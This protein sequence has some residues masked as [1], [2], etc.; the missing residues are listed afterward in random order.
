MGWDESKG[1]TVVQ[2]TK[3][4]FVDY[5]FVVEPDIKPFAVADDLVEK[6]KS[7]VGE[8]PE[9]KR[10]RLKKDYAL[11]DFDVET[12]TSSR[13][14]A[15]WFEEAAAGTKN[16]KR[17]ANIIL[18]ELLAKLNE[19]KKSIADVE[20]SPRHISDLVNAI[21]SRRISSAQGKTVFAKMMQT[22][23]SVD[24]II[25]EEKMEVVSDESAIE[26]IVEKV[27]Q[28]NPKAIADFKNGKTNVLGWLMGQVMKESRGNANPSSASEMIQ[29]KLAE[30]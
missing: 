12:L 29:K 10:I 6:A 17:A 4:S 9:A 7:K 20:I 26:S 27:L 15:V 30:L 21:D 13:D 19:E 2:R 23:K 3:N 1:R 14:L 5:R 25:R 11:S 16:P 28:S 8:L 22:K 18:T 24:E